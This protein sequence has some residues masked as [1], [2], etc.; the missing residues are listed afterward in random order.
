MSFGWLKVSEGFITDPVWRWVAVRACEPEER[1]ITLAMAMLTAASVVDDRG[2][3][4]GFRA[5]E[6]Q[7]HYAH[8]PPGAVTRIFDAMHGRVH[9]GVRI[10]GW[11]KWQ[12]KDPTADARKERQRLL[13][14]LQEERA[15]RQRAEARADAAI[16]LPLEPVTVG[17][18]DETREEEDYY[19]TP[20]DGSNLRVP[21][22]HSAE[23][24]LTLLLATLGDRAAPG[25]SDVSV[26]LGLADGG[27]G[28]PCEVDLDILPAIRARLPHLNPGSIRTLRYFVEPILTARNSRLAGVRAAEQQELPLERPGRKRRA[29]DAGAGGSEPG[30]MVDVLARDFREAQR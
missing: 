3:L 20:G 19:T 30:S 8:W 21:A 4:R 6:W 17:H 12:A 29:A 2:D 23:G 1:V 15:A 13:E 25:L 14:E 27:D 22:Q 28:P 5:D 11:D 16:Q 7:A 9:D 24:L 26:I 18:G 10:L